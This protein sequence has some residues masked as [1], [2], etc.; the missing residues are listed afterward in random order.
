MIPCDHE[1]MSWHNGQTLFLDGCHTAFPVGKVPIS[2]TQLFQIYLI[3]IITSKKRNK[4]HVCTE[5]N[6]VAR[7][8]RIGDTGSVVMAPLKWRV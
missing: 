5:Q 1:L 2:Q 4:K 6:R 7:I 3:N 8:R